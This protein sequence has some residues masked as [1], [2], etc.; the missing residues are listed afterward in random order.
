MIYLNDYLRQESIFR[1]VFTR[2]ETEENK[3]VTRKICTVLFIFCHIFITF[4]HM[5]YQI[6]S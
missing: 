6:P 1:K 5:T 2:P 3:I 4:S